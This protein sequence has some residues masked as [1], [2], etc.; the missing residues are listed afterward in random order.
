MSDVYDDDAAEP[1]GER[2][3]RAAARPAAGPGPRSPRPSSC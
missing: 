1:D 2:A 3:D